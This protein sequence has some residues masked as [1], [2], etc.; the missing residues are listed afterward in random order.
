LALITNA[1]QLNAISLS[2]N[3]VRSIEAQ[4]EL[5]D[6]VLFSAPDRTTYKYYVG[7]LSFLQED[8]AKVRCHLWPYYTSSLSAG[9]RSPDRCMEYLLL[10]KRWK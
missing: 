4:K 1:F 6:L 10:R 8:Y 7:V 5:P 3:V 2:K 9:R